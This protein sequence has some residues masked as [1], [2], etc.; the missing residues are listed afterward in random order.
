MYLNN[1]IINYM[2][3][4]ILSLKALYNGTINKYTAKNILPVLAEAELNG[5]FD[6]IDHGIVPAINTTVLAR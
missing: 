3:F 6:A 2:F 4:I 5:T 1:N